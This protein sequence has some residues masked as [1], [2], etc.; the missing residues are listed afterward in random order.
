[1]R[2]L[3][4]PLNTYTV[5]AIAIC[6]ESLEFCASIYSKVVPFCLD[7]SSGKKS[8]LERLL[9][10][11]CFLGR[12]V[13]VWFGDYIYDVSLKDEGVIRGWL[14]GFSLWGREQN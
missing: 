12:S 14:P 10:T 11:G 5:T 13:T 4:P 3:C 7:H 1:M 8:K 2:I 6:T 9:R